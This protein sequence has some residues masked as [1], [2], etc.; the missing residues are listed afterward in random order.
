MIRRCTIDDIENVHR[1]L[2]HPDIWDAIADDGASKE[3]F[4]MT[5][6]LE[7]E[8]TYVL[9]PHEDILFLIFPVNAITWD[10][11]INAL[12]EARGEA[13][14]V[15]IEVLEYMFTQTP[16]QKIIAY[17]AEIFPT[18]IRHTIKC[19]LGQ[20]G[21]LIGSYLKNG[22]IYNQHI[23]GITKSEFNGL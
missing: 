2:K 14:R 4:D 8:N 3:D 6:V 11:H 22:E 21:C 17:I 9:L 10:I 7:N 15:S 1:I 23:L 12:K 13:H 19:G 16:C 20:E 5:P 18:V